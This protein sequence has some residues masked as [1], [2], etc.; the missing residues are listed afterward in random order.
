MGGLYPEGDVALPMPP[1]FHTMS[2]EI[3]TWIVQTWKYEAEGETE[4]GAG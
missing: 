2:T 1:S 4:V 3:S